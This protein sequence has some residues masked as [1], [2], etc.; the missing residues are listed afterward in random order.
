MDENISYILDN[1][2]DL[3]KLNKTNL[4]TKVK[5]QVN[6]LI[7]YIESLLGNIENVNEEMI[8]TTIKSIKNIKKLIKE[9]SCWPP[10]FDVIISNKKMNIM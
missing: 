10:I 3:K 9:C 2:N 5:L 4:N 1:V 6:N 7:Y 8:N